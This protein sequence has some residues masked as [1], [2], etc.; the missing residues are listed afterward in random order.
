MKIREIGSRQK[1]F[2]M[3]LKDGL[4]D[5]RLSHKPKNGDSG[6]KAASNAAEDHG[7]DSIDLYCEPLEE[8]DEAFAQDL[9]VREIALFW[10]SD[11]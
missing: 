8:F 9:K 3:S 11:T 6:R 5:L 4:V 1:E 2:E 10:V 7:A